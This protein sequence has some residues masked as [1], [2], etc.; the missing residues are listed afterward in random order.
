MNDQIPMTNDQRHSGHW[1]LRHW[2]FSYVDLYSPLFIRLQSPKPFPLLLWSP[3]S[4]N[5]CQKHGLLFRHMPKPSS[6][7]PLSSGSCSVAFS[8]PLPACSVTK[9]KG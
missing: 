2:S 3:L 1:S 9:P 8:S 7:E 5:F 4:G 6:L